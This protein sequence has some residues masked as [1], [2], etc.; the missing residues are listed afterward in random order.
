MA[1]P[2]ID[3]YEI[4][5]HRGSQAD[6]FEE[7]CCQLANEEPIKDKIRFDRKGRGGDAG[8]ECF[9]TLADRSEVGWQ[10]KFYSSFDSMI[11]SLEKS[12]TTALNKHPVMNR[13][14]AC[15]PFDLSDS[16]KEDVKT[17]LSKWDAWK[18]GRIEAA[19]AAG[20]TI[21]I[22]R[23]DAHEIKLRLTESNIRSAGR[24]AFWFDKEMLT[25][26]WLSKAFNR[27]VDSL[28]ERYSPECHI[29][30]PVRR[31]ILATLRDPSVFDELLA[32]AARIEGRLEKVPATGD[33]GANSAAFAAAAVLRQAGLGRPEPFPLVDLTESV[34]KAAELALTWHDNLELKR[35]SMDK[36]DPEVAA[37]SNLVGALRSAG[38][39]LR[40]DRW[41]YLDRRALLILGEAGT[42]KS[43][44][45]ADACAHQIQLDRPTLMI[46]GGK[47][48]DAEP[49]G[50]IL[51]DLDLPKHLQVKQFLGALNA[52]GEAAGVRTLV[53]IDA[54]NEKNGQSIWPT[55]L[56][57][58]LSDLREFPWI[59]VVLSCRSTYADVVI[60]S[61][62]DEKKLPRIEHLGFDDEDVVRY[63]AKRGI[64]VP[65]T[66]RQLDELRN[67]LFLRIAC[68]ALRADG[69]ALMPDSLVGV[70]AALELFTT[71]ASKRVEATLGVAPMRRIARKAIAALAEE[72]AN[73]GRGQVGHAR[74]DA[75]M[76]SIHDGQEMARDLLFQLANEGLLAIEPDPYSVAGDDEVVRFAFERVGDHAIAANLLDRS[77]QHG[78]NKLCEPGSPLNATLSDARSRIVPGLLEALAV[79]LPER[80]EVELPDLAGL[81]SIGWIDNAFAKSL[82]TRCASAFCDRTWQL[83]EDKCDSYFRYETLIALAS[84]P[85][86]PF[87]VNYLDAQLRTFRMPERDAG[88]SAHLAR[89]DRANHLVNWAWNADQSRITKGRAELAAVQLTWFLTATHRPLR[90]CATK[91]LVVLLAGRP[92]LAVTLWDRFKDVDDGY[93]T[94]RVVASLY[95]AAM[96]GRWKPN[97]LTAVARKLYDDLFADRSPPTNE[98]LRNH[99][100]GLIGY[101]QHHGDPSAI[102]PA[103][104]EPPFKSPWPIDH[105]SDET[106]D[107]YSQGCG[108][109]GRWRDQIVSSCLDGDFGRYVLDYA[110]QDWSPAPIGTV[111]LPTAL[112]LRQEWY[113]QFSATA[114]KEMK[115]AHDALVATIAQQNLNGTFINREKRD[116]IN[117]AKAA[118]RALVGSD[119]FEEWREKAEYWRAE[120][121]YQS[122]ARRG[123][124]EFNLAWARRWVVM[125]AHQLGWT[126]DLHGAFDQGIRSSRS[127]HSLER[128]GKKYQWLALYELVARMSDNL[129][130][131]PDRGE[132]RLRLRNLDPSLLVTRTSDDGWKQFEVN[133]FWTGTPPGLPAKTPATA[134]AWLHSDEDI[135]DGID[136]VAVTSPHDNRDWLVLTGFETW[137]ASASRISTE[138]WRRVSCVVVGASDIGKAINI[139]SGSHLTANHDLPTAIGGGYRV[140]LGEFPWHTLDESHDDWIDEWRP[141]GSSERSG[142]KIPALPTTA[143]Y[144]AESAGYD[145]SISD[146]IN[147]HLPAR[148]IMDGLNLRLTDGQSI[149]Y[150]DGTD[151]V[152]FWDP[153][154][155]EA[156]RSV[157]L[158]DRT[159]FLDLLRRQGLVAIW[160]IAGEKNAYGEGHGDRFGGRFTFTR[161]YHSDGDQIRELPRFQTYDEPHEEQ[162][163]EFLDGGEE[164]PEEEEAC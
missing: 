162:L 47:L 125:R 139:M 73:A 116:H 106:M 14:V 26:E 95:G 25:G 134:I 20:R 124:T 164:A 115:D 17:A 148:W 88:W 59:T 150:Q 110:V 111:E 58:L 44:L 7:L 45:L 92:E 103:N 36:P 133:A 67:P 27:V 104:L 89:S 54:L 157:A 72:M 91:A 109:S 22:D 163:A 155:S 21:T 144:S 126:E 11:G 151:I 16:R 122:F 66:P 65:E 135:L 90:D 102:D 96:Q 63:L 49:W 130:R 147:L 42:G 81:P 141:D 52:A 156:G 149:V 113:A 77:A 41:A 56:P 93:V 38:R 127:K 60:P 87:N 121:M 15:F 128:I 46:L 82:L 4:R 2:D 94:E 137:H 34:D 64:S 74:A 75:L 83:V 78:T 79:Q 132:D 152:R 86:H 143:E 10:V 160:A 105:V 101:A 68:D 154:V 114:T 119:A 24:I 108:E 50:E 48:P 97:A 9:A 76:R 142:V 62:L 35:T 61:S 85:G 129:A 18:D 3:M 5:Q 98:L 31:T 117:K 28:G 33:S 37:V 71:E 8:V 99:A 140:H 53:A 123:P 158:V 136:V 70:S 138:S 84:E 29:D 107:T 43:H 40:S 30:L 80:F 12:L 153:S 118:F 100:L 13:F 55:R 19:K 131:L 51:R 145:G 57:G 120:G 39:G 159:A 1:L 69:Q 161:L 112:G 23:W 32:F 146:N 6:A